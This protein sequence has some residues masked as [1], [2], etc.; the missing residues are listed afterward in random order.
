MQTHLCEAWHLGT[1]NRNSARNVSRNRILPTELLSIKAH[2]SDDEAGICSVLRVT[3]RPSA[4]S[5]ISGPQTGY[6][7]AAGGSLH[8]TWPRLKS[9]L[10]SDAV[11]VSL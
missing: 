11:D 4:S 5:A 8:K 9:T 10:Q 2:Q 3:F 6:K 7:G 1:T